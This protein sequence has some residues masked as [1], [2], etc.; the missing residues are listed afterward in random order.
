MKKVKRK[1]R[2]VMA[3]KVDILAPID[4]TKLGTEEDPCF[5][6]YFDPRTPECS[7]CGDSEICA[8][9]MQQLNHIRR[10]KLEE[11]G[12]FKDLED[13]DLKIDRKEVRKN[14][15]KR[16]REMA[17]MA[18]KSGV[19]VDEVINDVHAS[20]FKYGFTKPRVK[21]ILEAMPEKSSNLIINKNTLQWKA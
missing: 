16:I 13:V 10:D 1:P 21:K 4:L 7:R 14:V 15:K 6:K 20:Y 5:G 8:I 12:N 2:N 18:G 9:K 17:K 3:K 19:K 11:K